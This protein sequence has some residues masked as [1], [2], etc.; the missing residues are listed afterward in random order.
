ML[1]IFDIAD[2]NYFD[3]KIVKCLF[4]CTEKEGSKALHTTYKE[5]LK[6]V[7]LT[8]QIAFGKYQPDAMP[9]V[10]FFDVVGNDRK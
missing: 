1:Y 8:K 6:L 3:I 2:F 5:K 4:E 9:E 10:G 7:A